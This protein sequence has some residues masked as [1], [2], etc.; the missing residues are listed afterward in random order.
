MTTKEQIL[1][2]A[3]KVFEKFGYNKTSMSDIAQAARKS[4]RTLYSYFANKEEIFQA[5]IEVEIDA[6]AGTLSE[7][8]E[9]PIPACN[10]L[11]EY[12]HIRMNAVKKLTIYYDAIRRDL[13]DNLGLIEK[14]RRNYDKM[15]REMISLMLK[16]GVKEGAFRITDPQL[17]AGAI[18]MAT[19][20]FELPLIMGQDGYDHNQLIDPLIDMFYHGILIK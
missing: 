10:K 14:I 5:V 16:Q 1:S 8:I 19:K 17:V 12:M 3:R 4:R 13:S 2:E 7:L 9:K 15:E 20:G 6:L 18:V 11:R